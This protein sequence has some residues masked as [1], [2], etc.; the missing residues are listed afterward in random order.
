MPAPML[1]NRF[2]DLFLGN[3]ASRPILR[4]CRPQFIGK[5]MGFK[6]HQHTVNGSQNVIRKP[7]NLL[8]QK[9]P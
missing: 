9:R 7:V 5:S 3:T 8:M 2:S 4:Q 1:A 6:L